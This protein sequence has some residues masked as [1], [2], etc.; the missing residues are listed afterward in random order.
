MC[1]IGALAVGAFGGEF[2]VGLL[3]RWGCDATLRCG[4]NAGA[5]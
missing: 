4:Y 3:V 2:G 1:E 5:I